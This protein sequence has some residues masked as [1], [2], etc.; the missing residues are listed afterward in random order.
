[1]RDHVVMTTDPL[2]ALV[3]DAYRVVAPR[4]LVAGLD[5]GGGQRD[6]A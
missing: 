5:A 2:E 1:M 3:A 4:R 6:G